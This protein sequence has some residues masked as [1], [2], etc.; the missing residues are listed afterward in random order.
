MVESEFRAV[1][2]ADKIKQMHFERH[3]FLDTHNTGLK[4]V[5][6]LKSVT[7]P[8]ICADLEIFLVQ[9]SLLILK[10]VSDPPN[11]Y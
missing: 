6:Y 10:I 5:T 2:S 7:D 8:K 1:H 11:Y 4:I 3:E 9:K